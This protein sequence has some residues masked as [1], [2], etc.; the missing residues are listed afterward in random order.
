MENKANKF[1][2]SEKLLTEIN[3]CK[4]FEEVKSL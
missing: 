3:Q 1:V 4:T 2:K